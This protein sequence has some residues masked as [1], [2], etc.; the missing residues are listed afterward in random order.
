[1]IVLDCYN[2]FIV[3]LFLELMP[4]ANEPVDD[5]KYSEEEVVRMMRACGKLYGNYFVVKTSVSTPGEVAR[6]IQ[7]TN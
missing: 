7:Q 4:V 1:M 5:R 2:N 6:H 3:Y